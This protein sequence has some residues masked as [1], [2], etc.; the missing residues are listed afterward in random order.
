MFKQCCFLRFCQ[1][2]MLGDAVWQTE[3]DVLVCSRFGGG[4]SRQAFAVRAI[5]VELRMS[6]LF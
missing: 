3:S 4:L 5:E 6:L 2:S 1:L